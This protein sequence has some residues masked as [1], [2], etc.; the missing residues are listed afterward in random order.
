MAD[1]SLPTVAEKNLTNLTTVDDVDELRAVDK[2][3]NSVNLPINELTLAG[4]KVTVSVEGLSDTVDGAFADVLTAIAEKADTTQVEALDEEKVDKTQSVLAG[5]GMTG[6][7]TLAGDVTLNV[8]TADDSLVVG[9]DNVKVNTYNGLDSTSS[10]RPLSAA[11]GKALDVA[12]VNKAGNETIAGVKTFSSSPIVPTPTTDY[13]AAPKSYV[14]GAVNAKI[15]GIKKQVGSESLYWTRIY[16]EIHAERRVHNLCGRYLEDSVGNIINLHPTN[17]RISAQGAAVDLSG[18]QG[19]VWWRKPAYYFKAEIVQESDG[20]MYERQ[21]MSDNYFPGATYMPE[22]SCSPWHMCVN[23][24]TNVAASLSFLT[25]SGNSIARDVNGLPVY[26]ANASTYRGGD[27][28]AT[29]DGTAKSRIGMG[30]TNINRAAARGYATA[31]GAHVGF[32]ALMDEIRI[33]YRF[34]YASDDIQ[35]AY[36]ATLDAYGN[37]QGGLGTGKSVASG[38]WSTFNGY[39]PFIPTGVTAPLGNQTGLVNYVIKDWGGVGIDKTIQVDSFY[40]LEALSEYLTTNADDVLIYNDTVLGRIKAYVCSN[41][42]QLA[43]PVSDTSTVVPAGYKLIADLPLVSGYISAMSMPPLSFPT[44]VVGGA[45]NKY[46]PD[47]Y[48]VPGSAGWFA[49]GLG[50]YAN[51]GSNAGLACLHASN[52]VSLAYASWGFRLCR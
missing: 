5:A 44:S 52:R 30:V 39:N 9:A 12:K 37:S 29:Y 2:A 20:L 8:A 51:N 22:R 4:T 16:P 46:V 7:G 14:D 33:L 11:Q 1:N 48:S 21:W 41:P 32:F 23:R 6:G 45:S 42:A 34:E 27:N 50:A 35:L 38:E 3:G 28:N 49:A 18:S 31:A 19:N 15:W 24:S 43:N 17:S 26:T 10:T 36:N 47:Y 25:W 40:G 13:Q